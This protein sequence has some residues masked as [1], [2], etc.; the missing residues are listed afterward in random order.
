MLPHG[1]LLTPRGETLHVPVQ[2]IVQR[3]GVHGVPLSTGWDIPLL[4][5]WGLYMLQILHAALQAP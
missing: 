1:R 4:C 2:G 5:M 3:P